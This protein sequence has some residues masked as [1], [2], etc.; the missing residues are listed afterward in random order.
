[1][2]DDDRLNENS[3]K[4]VHPFLDKELDFILLLSQDNNN[5]QTGIYTIDNNNSANKLFINL[6]DKITFGNLIVNVTIANKLRKDDPEVFNK[7]IGTS[8][9]YCVIWEMLISIYSSGK[10]AIICENAVDKIDVAK[11]W[12][13]S[14]L[15]VHLMHPRIWYKTMPQKYEEA[16]EIVYKKYLAEIGAFRLIASYAKY[17]HINKHKKKDVFNY[18]ED[19]PLILK[20]KMKVMFFMYPCLAFLKKQLNAVLK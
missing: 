15:E 16:R 2:G 20:I 1:L 6:W 12:S 3:F 18:I 17:I 9:A 10:F 13:S 8:H 19:F 7:Y 11:S 14:F 4:L 5:Y